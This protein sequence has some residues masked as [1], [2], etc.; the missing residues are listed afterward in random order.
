[1]RAEPLNTRTAGT[2]TNFSP[3]LRSPCY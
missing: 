1:V 3:R 2:D